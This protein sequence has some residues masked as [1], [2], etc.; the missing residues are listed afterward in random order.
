VLEGLDPEELEALLAHEIA[1]LQSHDVSV[2]FVAGLLRDLVAW[3]P[4]GHL[5]YRRLMED[6][7]LEADR[8]AAALTSRPLAVASGLIKVC[9]LLGARKRRHRF[10]LGFFAERGGVKR[11]VASLL[12][13]A[14]GRLALGSAG[15]IPYVFAAVAVAVL[16]LQVGARVAAESP[17]VVIAWAGSDSAVRTWSPDESRALRGQAPKPVVPVKRQVDQVRPRHFAPAGASSLRPRDVP[18]WFEAMDRWTKRQ[19]A[20]FVRM[21][22]RS[23]QNWEATPL[24]AQFS[25]GPFELYRVAPYAF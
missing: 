18:A 2:T 6:R 25:M 11:R 24:F 5:A 10:A 21:R 20:E 19:R 8:R 3:N 17:A 14:D 4:V 16:G 13:A 22:W 9:E 1:H 23:R 7:E 15:N 12:D